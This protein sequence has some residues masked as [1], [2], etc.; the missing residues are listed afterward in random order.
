VQ[1]ALRDKSKATKSGPVDIATI[2]MYLQ[3]CSPRLWYGRRGLHLSYRR[4]VCLEPT[5]CG[6]ECTKGTTIKLEQNRCWGV[7]AR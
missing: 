4:R 5:W 3:Q 7:A 1:V 6:W 2:F